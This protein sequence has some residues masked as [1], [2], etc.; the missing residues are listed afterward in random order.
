MKTLS[1]V[2]LISAF[3]LV[4]AALAAPVAPASFAGHNGRIYFASNLEPTGYFTDI[5]S[6]TPK[7]TD[8]R[9]VKMIDDW[10]RDPAVSPNGRWIAFSS[11]PEQQ[12]CLELWSMSIHGTQ[13]KPMDEAPTFTRS[14]VVV[15]PHVDPAVA[16]SSDG[17]KM[18]WPQNDG[19]EEDPNF[20][21]Y[22]ARSDGTHERQITDRLGNESQ[23]DFAPNGR[24]L[25]YVASTAT[26]G[27]DIF[28]VR[29]N[30]EDVRRLTHGERS[31]WAPDYSPNG[32]RIVFSA[33]LGENPD[34]F[35][36]SAD[37]EHE[38]AL[39]RRKGFIVEPDWGVKPRG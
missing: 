22:V 32:E 29:A 21:I 5:F 14:G 18:A 36:M 26:S 27:D 34:I 2:L 1:R 16:Y 24:R 19:T 7:G 13:L 11:E 9:P 15:W 12:C 35:K 33:D 37:G 4:G 8:V 28:D 30:G 10:Q 6:M 38:H 23:P 3:A 31:Q 20:N 25:A 17:S 39:T